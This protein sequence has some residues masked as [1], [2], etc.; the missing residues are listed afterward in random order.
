M[1]RSYSFIEYIYTYNFNEDEP[2]TQSLESSKI[3]T[4]GGGRR[5]ASMWSGLGAR[6]LIIDKH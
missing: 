6:I 2:T 3:V 5:T 1:K 4:T